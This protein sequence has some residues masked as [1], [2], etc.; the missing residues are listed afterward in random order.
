[1]KNSEELPH[2]LGNPSR[3]YDFIFQNQF[4]F[5]FYAFY[6]IFRLINNQ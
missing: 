1:M 2:M 6:F 5:L 4:P 3:V